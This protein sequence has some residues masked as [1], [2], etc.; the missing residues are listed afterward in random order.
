MDLL[1]LVRF[2]SL[3]NKNMVVGTGFL[4]TKKHVVTCAHVLNEA[5]GVNHLSETKPDSSFILDIPYSKGKQAVTANVVQWLPVQ[6]EESRNSGDIAILALRDEIPA[7]IHPVSLLNEK[8]LENQSYRTFG[9]PAGKGYT[10]GTWVKGEILGQNVSGWIQ[11][12]SKSKILVQGGF[13]GAPVWKENGRGVIG[14]VASADVKQGIAFAIPVSKLLDAF[15]PLKKTVRTRPRG[16]GKVFIPYPRNE[17]FVGRD[18]F[19]EYVHDELAGTLSKLLGLTGMGGIGKTTLAVQFAQQYR[20][21]FSDGVYWFNAANPLAGEFSN[22]AQNLE[23]AS[24]ELDENDAARRAWV[25]LNSKPDALLIFDDVQDP[26]QLQ[27][28]F[29][30]EL[31]ALH[32]P[33][34]M[35]FTS[36]KK[37]PFKSLEMGA[38]DE[39]AAMRLLL[40]S[41]EQVQEGKPD[42]ARALFICRF[43]GHL[44]LALELVATYLKEYPEVTLEGYLN[45]LAKE[46]GFNL[47]DPDIV[48]KTSRQATL[49]SVLQTQWKQ[50]V[51]RDAQTI[52][53]AAGQ[54]ANLESIPIPWLGLLTGIP[55][56]FEPGYPARITPPIN[57]LLQITLLTRLAD[58]QVRLHPL[59]REF[60]ARLIP[61]K[62]RGSFQDKLEGH[63]MTALADPE[64]GTARALAAGQCLLALPWMPRKARGPVIQKL[65]E[66]M[67]NTHTPAEQKFQ[68]AL[69]LTQLNWLDD[70]EQITAQ[71]L[72]DYLERVVRSARAPK[73]QRS[74]V[75]GIT[76]LFGT[77]DVDISDREKIQLLVHRAGLQG[78]LEDYALASK[79]FKQAQELLKVQIAVDLQTEDYKTLARITYGLANLASIKGEKDPR[80]REKSYREAVALYEVAYKSAQL[81]DKDKILEAII[82]R[83]LCSVH[84]RLKEWGKAKENLDCAQALVEGNEFYQARLS[85]SAVELLLAQGNFLVDSS[86]K[87]QGLEQLNLA[88]QLASKNIKSIKKLQPESKPLIAAHLLA[89]DCAFA[90]YQVTKNKETSEKACIEWRAAYSLAK[91]VGFNEYTQEACQKLQNLPDCQFKEPPCD[92]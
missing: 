18:G 80:L 11:M 67:G 28:P 7:D 13:S 2:Y 72:L 19:L 56:E 38:L 22:L 17:L 48:A 58:N 25:Y 34:W 15:P 3:K 26:A 82:L 88:Y 23:L 10:N 90:L 61:G 51:D 5:L 62:D 91:R 32:L 74:M 79:D 6:T 83:D 68:S 33:G 50:V 1:G 16:G 40:H 46:G 85:E 30:G 66:Q 71:E 39:E 47:I 31:T 59:V 69:L 52:F 84:V 57:Q 20:A 54:L 60:S 65:R 53:L 77:E 76:R 4:A 35:L 44:P 41:R 55:S 29:A 45:R 63:L 81:Y 70:V 36:R 8:M 42:W 43:L 75:N 64:Y 9:F 78:Y 37:S 14:M 24:S 21:Y 86:N 89:G 12:E 49:D 27:E 73:Y 92:E 87:H